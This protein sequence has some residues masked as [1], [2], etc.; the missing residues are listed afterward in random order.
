MKA[1]DRIPV[2]S[3]FKN[4]ISLNIFSTSNKII[5]SA[6]VRCY[7]EWNCFNSST[8]TCR[9]WSQR[10]LSWFLLSGHLPQASRMLANHKGDNEVIVRTTHTYPR[11][12]LTAKENPGKLQ[13]GD[14]WWKLCD[15]SSIT[16]DRVPYLQMRSGRIAQYVRKGEGRKEGNYGVWT[17]QTL[18]QTE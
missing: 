7:A 13:L 11:I 14:R 15:Q 8:L 2:E 18:D 3:H 12:C 10:F 9:P 16:L 1:V 4:H 6:S 17:Y 5:M